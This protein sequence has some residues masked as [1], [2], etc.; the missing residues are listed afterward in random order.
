MKKK[1][2]K[3]NRKKQIKELYA[4][5]Y[6]L[7]QDREFVKN[8]AISENEELLNLF[9]ST[10]LWV[11]LYSHTHVE[12]VITML[13]LMGRL[14]RVIEAAKAINRS[15]A[16][17][18]LVNELMDEDF[19]NEE[20]DPLDHLDDR[21]K[22]LLFAFCLANI[23]NLDALAAFRK[24]MNQLVQ[25]A[26]YDNEALFNAVLI[27]RTVVAHPIIAGKIR[28][29]QMIGDESFMAELA[30]SVSQ[31]RAR[32]RRNL[33][34]SRMMIE[35]MDDVFGLDSFTYREIAETLI[36]DLEILDET[37]GHQPTRIKKDLYTRNKIRGK[38]GGK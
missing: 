2:K 13:S 29:A 27:D 20:I 10:P 33:D 28:I 6:T 31:Q 3:P 34:E 9:K 32:R 26:A 22:G 12:V 19:E 14:D 15:Q 7:N 5:L 21:G 24:S 16:A 36:D 4:F 37:G 18:D 38:K 35:L 23:G 11:E 1:K 25:E 17:I 8:A 30:K